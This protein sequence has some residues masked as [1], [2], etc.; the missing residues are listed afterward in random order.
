MSGVKL[1]QFSVS[2]TS[3]YGEDGILQALFNFKGVDR[4]YFCEFGAW[5]GRHLSNSFALY[6]AGWKGC[7]IEGSPSRFEDLKAN[8]ST[9]G[10]ALVCAF[11]RSQGQNTLDRILAKNMPDNTALDL[12]S[13][14]I[15]SDDLAI[16]KS[17]KAVRPR[18]VVIEF[19]PTIP[20]DVHYQN[21]PGMNRGN[22]ARAI[23]DFGTSIGYELVAATHCNLIMI[24]REF[25]MGQFELVD[26]YDPGIVLGYR[27]F[28]GFDGTLL[29]TDPRTRNA[30]EPEFFVVPWSDTVFPQPIAKPFRV[31]AEG[32]LAGRISGAFS[33][34]S[35]A[36]RRPFSALD[37]IIRRRK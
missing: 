25:N 2:K 17:L 12:L 9:P 18:V 30:E 33:R 7:Y 16:W 4:G 14:D 24:D 3:Q 26:L 28:F 15:D 27:Y 5:D 19:N 11:V 8:I 36:I 20:L 10:M 32:S 6:E 23:Y 13:I 22:S 1:N 21:P 35:C 29:V 34:A 37:R 31:F